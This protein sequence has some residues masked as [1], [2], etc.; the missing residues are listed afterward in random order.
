MRQP[1]NFLGHG[2]LFLLSE[3]CGVTSFYQRLQTVSFSSPYYNL[4]NLL[5]LI[6]S[7][8]DSE[9]EKQEMASALEILTEA[10]SCAAQGELLSA[11]TAGKGYRHFESAG[12]PRLC[13]VPHCSAR[14]CLNPVSGIIRHVISEA[15][16]SRAAAPGRSP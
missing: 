16:F 14:A 9:M 6:C 12:V 8:A 11:Q 3:W 10:I 7:D 15:S 1:Y 5:H 4:R 13:L 2:L